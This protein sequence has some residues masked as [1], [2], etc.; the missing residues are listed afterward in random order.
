ML[1]GATSGKAF[2]AKPIVAVA[3]G[4]GYQRI[5]GHRGRVY[6]RYHGGGQQP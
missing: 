4:Q 6:H 1:S 2:R 3:R 5:S